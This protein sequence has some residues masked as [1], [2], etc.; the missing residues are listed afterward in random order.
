MCRL[1]YLNETCKNH[2]Y[3]P[4]ANVINMIDFFCRDWITF[5]L[6][7]DT[8]S[9]S[10]TFNKEKK[11]QFNH[12]DEYPQLGHRCSC[13]ISKQIRPRGKNRMQQSTPNQEIS[14]WSNP[15]WHD[16]QSPVGW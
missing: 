2:C 1:K 4:S 16:G 5:K 13:M 3:L 6:I 14:A 7:F 15:T 8:N 12:D 10:K 9:R 11:S